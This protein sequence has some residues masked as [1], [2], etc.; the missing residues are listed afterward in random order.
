[1][2]S[3]RGRRH[4]APLAMTRK[5]GQ[6]PN[7]TNAPKTVTRSVIIG[8]APRSAETPAKQHH[9]QEAR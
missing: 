9:P 5:Q 7:F 3:E 6:C 8:V 2:P 4:Q 1:M